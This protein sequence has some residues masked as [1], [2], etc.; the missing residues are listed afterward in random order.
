VEHDLFG[1]PGSIRGSSPGTGHFPDHALIVEPQDV[2]PGEAEFADWC[3]ITDAGMWSVTIVAVKPDWQ[4]LGSLAR[5]LVGL[6]VGPLVQRGLDEALSLAV[7]FR[8]VG[9]GADVLEVEPLAEPAEGEG[10]VAG[11]VVGHDALDPD[12]EALVIGERGLEEG[13]GTAS[14]LAVHNLGEGDARSIVDGD[15]DELPTGPFAACPQ[16]ALSSTVAGDAMADTV[17]SAKLLD[18]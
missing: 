18:I 15:M 1:K 3:F 14:P 8:G 2:I 17:D 6:G 16:V 12:A 10:L 4:I 7:G 11:T 5:M 9:P 13:G